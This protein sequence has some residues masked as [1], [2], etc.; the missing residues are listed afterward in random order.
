MTRDSLRSPPRHVPR[1][2]H[3]LGSLTF[4][5]GFVFLTIGRSEL[6]TENFE[7]R[8]F[9]DGFGEGGGVELAVEQLA[10]DTFLHQRDRGDVGHAVPE[11][12]VLLGDAPGLAAK[13]VQRSDRLARTRIG[14]ACTER[15]PLRTAA[16]ANVG[17]RSAYAA[18]SSLKTGAAR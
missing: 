7:R 9:R 13:E 6:F 18:R 14:M 2:P 8:A 10:G 15:K 4:G 16:G 3:V 11:R 12:N 17:Q 1:R 5:V